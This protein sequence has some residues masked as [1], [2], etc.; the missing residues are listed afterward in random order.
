MAAHHALQ[1][2]ELMALIIE[3]IMHGGYMLDWD[4]SPI[5]DTLNMALT[6][7]GFTGPALDALWKVLHNLKP[8][9]G[10][11]GAVIV[12][13]QYVRFPLPVVHLV[14]YGSC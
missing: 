7:K 11:L 12:D 9:M 4:D 2:T 6:C 3:Q 14:I 8:V 13:G 5:Q 10:L 1:I